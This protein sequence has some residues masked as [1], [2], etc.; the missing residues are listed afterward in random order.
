MDNREVLAINKKEL[1]TLIQ[2]V[3]KYAKDIGMKNMSWY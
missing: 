1:E 3:K 2:A